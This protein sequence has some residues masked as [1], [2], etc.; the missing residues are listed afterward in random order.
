MPHRNFGNDSTVVIIETK[1]RIVGNSRVSG[2]VHLLECEFRMLG[3]KE[4]LLGLCALVPF[5][6]C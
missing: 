2:N 1:I 5:R 4:R 3:R 6:S